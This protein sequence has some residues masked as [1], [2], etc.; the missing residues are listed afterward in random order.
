[1]REK[2]QAL[3]RPRCKAG[4]LMEEEHDGPYPVRV[5]HDLACLHCGAVITNG[6]AIPSKERTSPRKLDKQKTRSSS[7]SPSPAVFIEP[8]QDA[9]KAESPSLEKLAIPPITADAVSS[10]RHQAPSPPAR[11][12]VSPDF[13]VEGLDLQSAGSSAESSGDEG[14]LTEHIQQTLKRGFPGCEAKRS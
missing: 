7:D 2:L 10:A 4:H 14:I 13:I 8:V 1:M 9:P 12:E 3:I 6:S 11:I 5:Q